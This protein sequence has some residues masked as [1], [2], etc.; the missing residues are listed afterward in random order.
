[1]FKADLNAT[2]KLDHNPIEVK[3]FLT[4]AF[5]YYTGLYE[6]LWEGT[7][8]LDARYPAIYYNALN[9]HD[10]QFMLVLSACAI[11]DPEEEEK[12][13]VVST[14]L[15]RMF[16]LLELQGAYDSN[17]FAGRLFEVSA[18]I[19]EKP[20]G[21][22]R[23]Y[24]T[25]ILVEEIGERRGMPAQQPFAYSLFRPM[26]VDRLNTRFTRYLFS[27]VESALATGMNQ[28]MRHDVRD[29]V[30]LRGVKNGFRSG[31]GFLNN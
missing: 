8:T 21:E 17:E 27:R 30:T 25:G 13:R 22:F 3:G 28:K 26:S 1:M 29:L 12:M 4:K 14:G 6:R 10:V 24:S 15:D 19:R 5:E 9:E 16:S 20:V 2:L 18:A 11:D 31:L 23:L 7:T